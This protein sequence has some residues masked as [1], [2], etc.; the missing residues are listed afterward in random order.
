[1]Y[2]TVI[3]TLLMMIILPG[4]IKTIEGA[5]YYPQAERNFLIGISTRF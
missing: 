3:F 4:I 2:L 5:G 1:M